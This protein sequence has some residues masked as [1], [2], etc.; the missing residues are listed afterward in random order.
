MP[1]AEVKVSVLDRAFLLGDG[2]YEVIRAYNGRPWKLDEHLDRLSSSLAAVQIRGVDMAKIRQRIAATLGNSGLADALVYV[3]V[4]RGEARRTHHFPLEYVPNQLIYVDEFSDPYL[5][6]RKTGASVITHPDIRW[7]KNYIKATSL[8]ANCLAAQAAVEAGATEAVLVDAAGSVTEGSH[9]SVFAVKD[10]HILVCPDS[11]NILPGITKRQVVAL[12]GQA[13]IPLRDYRL[14]KE[15][16]RT[17]EELFLSGTPEEILPVTT[18]DGQKVGDGSV[19][20]VTR[21]LQES[22]R[23][24]LAAWLERTSVS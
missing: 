6:L 19:G 1:L 17:V 15:D 4:T 5:E 18:V 14:R 21:S 24:A 13:K 2:V 8:L 9:T 7:S 22:F 11:P 16:L 10:G 23:A 12:A 3:Q 20:K